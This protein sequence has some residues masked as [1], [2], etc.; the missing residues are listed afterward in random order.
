MKWWQNV[1]YVVWVI[2]ILMLLFLNISWLLL[3]SVTIEVDTRVPGALMQWGTIGNARLWYE[4]KWWLTMQI[5][6]YKKTLLVSQ[7]KRKPRKIGTVKKR[8]K[9][10][11]NISRILKIIFQITKT[12]RVTYWSLAVDTGDYAI[13]APLYVL[14]FFPNT[15]KHVR[16]NFHNENYLVLKAKNSLWNI[17]HV[18]LRKNIF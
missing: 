18:Y 17:L 13:N 15:S 4:D 11:M 12:F 16:V 2:C 1:D 14:N 10:A 7:I 9:K 6:F 5:L 8:A 3:S